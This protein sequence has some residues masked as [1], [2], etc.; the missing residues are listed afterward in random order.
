MVTKKK[1]A[2][3]VAKRQVS[4]VENKPAKKEKDVDISIKVD[5]IERAIKAGMKHHKKE[6][7]KYNSSG[8]WVFGSA[9]AITFS[10]AQN[11][12]IW[13]AILHGIFSWFYVIYR[14]ILLYV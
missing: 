12:N 13:W 8:F 6:K 7:W 9:L 1:A 3:K 5:N 4:N 2:K 10:Y 14:I 11:T